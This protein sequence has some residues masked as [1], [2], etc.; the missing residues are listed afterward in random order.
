MAYGCV[1]GYH[2]GPARL[3]EAITVVTVSPVYSY[4]RLVL[5]V[6][7]VI[8]AHSPMKSTDHVVANTS[9]L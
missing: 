6:R 2:R 8:K 7:A 4:G 1:Y 9:V 5:I 3:L